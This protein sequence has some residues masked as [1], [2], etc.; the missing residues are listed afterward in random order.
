AGD[1]YWAQYAPTMTA[2]G[3]SVTL[4]DLAPTTDRWDFAAVEVIPT[5]PPD[6]NAS[7]TTSATSTTAE[8]QSSS[9]STTG[10]STTGSSTTGPSTTNPSKPGG[11]TGTTVSST[12]TTT[13]AG[14]VPAGVVLQSID[15][16]SSFYVSHGATKAAPLDNA[17]FFPI[18]VWYPSLNS[19][20][21]VTT[22]QSL[23]INMLDRPDGNCHLSLL[24]GTGIY[25]IPQYGECGGA[26]GAGIGNESV[27]LF[28]DDEVDMNYGPSTGFTY[29]N[30]LISGVP[31][32]VKSGRF[33]WS[34]YG[35][36]VMIWETPSQAAQFVNDYQQTVSD[37]YYWFT[38]SN[39]N[40]PWGSSPW[41]Q[42]A[43]FYG[44]N[45]DCTTDEA[46]RGSNYGSS[47]DA[48]RSLESPNGSEPI[49]AFIEDGYPFTGDSEFITPAEMNWAMWSS[50]IHGARGIVYFNHSFSGPQQG[51]NNFEN[52]YYTTTGIT[53]QAEATDALIKSLAAVLN[54]DTA[55]HY[56]TANPAP[57]TFGGIETMAKYH[58][59]VFTIFADTRDSGG[60]TAIP[61]TFHVADAAARSVTV[62]NENRTI[63]V[64]NGT[65]TDT[66]AT[67]STVHIY[68]VNG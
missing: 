44:L 27:G 18:G 50:I 65:F 42:C 10:S 52:P 37:D 19:T 30:N 23:G 28:T 33:F 41:D 39:I 68:Q 58:D 46:E 59:G 48:I 9:S 32:S 25:A 49:W 51:D 36:G 64:V 24:A 62:V 45:R 35:K 40:G 5:P 43:Q 1:T 16:G 57:S 21:D 67:G 60:A 22:Y 12:T 4:N 8:G 26:N 54:D 47:I 66:F 17:N 34:N 20:S 38:D 11:T 63:P 6:P 13:G 2:A 31:A 7:S 61:A 53:P 56:V 29:L 55:L 3:T 15:G 14:T